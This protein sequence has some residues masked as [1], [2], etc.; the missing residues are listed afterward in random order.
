MTTP[1]VSVP[2][3]VKD[4]VSRVR[5]DD[6]V[7][8]LLKPDTLKNTALHCAIGICSEAGE[9]ADN[10]KREHIYGKDP[11]IDNLIEELGDLLFYIQATMNVYG[12]D[13][14][15]LYQENADKLARRYSELTWSSKAAIARADK[16][17]ERI[18]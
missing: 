8:M 18:S 7:R 14:Q 16:Q 10:I 3:S 4:T 15:Q 1:F 6:F 13:W 11:N 12:L 17:N 2:G 9:L 5:Y